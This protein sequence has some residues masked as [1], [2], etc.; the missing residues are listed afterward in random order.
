VLVKFW[1]QISP[2]EQLRRFQA[3]EQEPWKQHKIT[4]ED[5]RNR[6]KT[7]QYE[8]A[9]SEMISRNSTEYAPF[10]LV[11]AEDKRYARIKVLETVVERLSREL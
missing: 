9:A 1:L 11:E 6:Q 5:Y 2:E 10:T 4:A 3:R 7:H 8:A